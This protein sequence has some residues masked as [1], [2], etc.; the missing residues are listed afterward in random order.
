MKH[1]ILALS[2]LMAGC[3]MDE[4]FEVSF[5]GHGELTYKLVFEGVLNG[6]TVDFD[7]EYYE[8][9]ANQV[10]ELSGAAVLNRDSTQA[11]CD[12]AIYVRFDLNDTQNQLYTLER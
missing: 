3:G 9:A 4:T 12:P 5:D 10:Y 2:I 1:T 8:C 11:S 7:D 6:A